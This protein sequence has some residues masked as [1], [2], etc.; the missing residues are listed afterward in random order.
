M[1]FLIDAKSGVP[2]YR[3]IIDQVK[4]AVACSR[5]RPGDRLPTVYQLAADLSI[6]PNT[7]LRA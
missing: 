6:S 2:F 4:V 7:V 1:Q 3:Q 5:F